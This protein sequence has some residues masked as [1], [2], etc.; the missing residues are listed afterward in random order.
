[1]QKDKV[2][3]NIDS[4]NEGKIEEQPSEESVDQTEPQEEKSEASD[5][6]ELEKD[7]TE[8]L[9]EE[10][11][12]SKDKYLRLYSEFEN[13]RRRTAKERI[14][15]IGSATKDLIVDLLPVLDDFERAFKSLDEKSEKESTAAREGL[16]II[17]NKFQKVL[18]QK[19][20]KKIAI[21]AG[22]KFD[23]ELQEA[24]TQTPA[25]KKLEG[26]VV[27]VIENG[28][29]LNDKVVRYAK[30]VTGAKS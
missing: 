4:K 20:L 21:K 9:Q 5:S 28:Y 6:E 1:M 2:E 11:S 14:D 7:E 13:F 16:E 30:V 17:Y 10:L 24:I 22:D 8:K 29:S 12:E 25:G 15:L 3:E 23:P 19:G 27:D 18:D 26:K